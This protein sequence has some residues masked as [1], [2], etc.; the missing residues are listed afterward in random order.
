MNAAQLREILGDL[1]IPALYYYEVVGSS[2]DLAMEWAAAGAEDG[3][4]VVADQQMK[5]RGRMGRAWV[6]RPGV[7]LAFSLILAP[8]AEEKTCLPLF[9]PA[10]ALA[11]SQAVEALTGLQT[12][13]KWPNDVL[14][15]RKKI[16]G[17]L[18]EANWMANGH[19]SLVVG[20]GVNVSAGSLPPAEELLFPATC[21]EQEAGR[22]I[23]RWELLQTILEKFFDLRAGIGSAGFMQ[24]WTDRL[25][26]RDEIVSVV[27][28]REEIY[29]G[30]IAGVDIQGNLRLKLASGREQKFS[31]G[32]VHLRPAAPA[33]GSAGGKLC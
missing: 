15:G 33:S 23:N 22:S 17:I 9:S 3:S 5:G 30:T 20:M 27:D 8:S 26:F 12:Q 1:P 4:L 24:A 13:I 2:N 19:T 32:D 6:T 7:A 18:A 16:S 28:Q 25:A 29:F 11:V 21:L 14:V 10:A 31:A